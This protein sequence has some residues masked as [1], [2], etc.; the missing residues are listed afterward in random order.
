MWSETNC[1]QQ[2]RNLADRDEDGGVLNFPNGT[3]EGLIKSCLSIT[4]YDDN[5]D[6]GEETHNP[7]KELKT[8]SDI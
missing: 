8:F 6:G 5:D 7:K 2:D 1:R 4:I 3:P